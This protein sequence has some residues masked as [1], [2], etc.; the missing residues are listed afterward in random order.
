MSNDKQNDDNNK[1]QNN[2]NNEKSKNYDKNSKETYNKFSEKELE[3]IQKKLTKSSNLSK[4]ESDNLMFLYQQIKNHYNSNFS[5][6]KIEN[7]FDTENAFSTE[8][9]NDKISEKL[10]KYYEKDLDEV[11]DFVKY[12]NLFYES[13]KKE[14]KKE[15]VEKFLFANEKM[16]I[17]EYKFGYINYPLIQELN[18]EISSIINKD[19]HVDF[20]KSADK[21]IEYVE[22]IKQENKDIEYDL[23]IDRSKLSL[24]SIIIQQVLKYGS[25][26]QKTLEQ[27]WTKFSDYIESDKETF[28]ICCLLVA[29]MINFYNFILIYDIYENDCKI[30]E[31]SIKKHDKNDE[32]NLTPEE[33][34]NQTENAKIDK[35]F[36]FIKLKM[37]LTNKAI[38][39][40]KEEG[41]K[42]NNLDKYNKCIKK[43]EYLNNLKDE[44][45]KSLQTIRTKIKDT[46]GVDLSNR[47]ILKYLR[48]AVCHNIEDD[49]RWS[50][51]LK[52]DKVFQIKPKI[53]QK[54]KEE[55][56]RKPVIEINTDLLDP[57]VSFFREYVDLVIEDEEKSERVKNALLNS[58]ILTDLQKYLTILSD[59]ND[60]KISDIVDQFIE[61]SNLDNLDD[62]QIKEVL[63]DSNKMSIFINIVGLAHL[64][65]SNEKFNDRVN[66]SIAKEC[67]INKEELENRLRHI[68]N[69]MVHAN[70][71]IDLKEGIIEFNDTKDDNSKEFFK[72]ATLN[73]EDIRVLSYIISLNMETK[74]EKRSKKQCSDTKSKNDKKLEKDKFINDE[75]LKI[76]EDMLTKKKKFFKKARRTIS[77]ILIDEVVEEQV[78]YQDCC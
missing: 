53:E 29:D 78:N 14:N 4:E 12:T 46:Y 54:N 63:N 41:L 60:Q 2:K 64:L 40:I 20:Y 34:F 62:E 13:V 47:D 72:I 70:Y 55:Q 30:K 32:N 6:D 25:E 48:D 67:G 11:V 71:K 61:N 24:Y 43:L 26:K 7:S 19:S 77:K 36:E 23:Y 74:S 73:D 18:K 44:C 27:A 69:S 56:N 45:K 22:K 49:E 33:K 50:F 5:K 16:N 59:S 1:Q 51:R 8:F 37:G 58:K 39:K 52:L 21:I 68:R 76:D 35:M 38:K 28:E 75:R 42:N 3:L 10:K 31:Q 65:F 9:K 17:I 66:E 15:T 57:I